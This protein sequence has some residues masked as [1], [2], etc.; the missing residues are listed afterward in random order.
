MSP[1][2]TAF[3]TAAMDDFAAD[4]GGWASE[5][6]AE[7]ADLSTALDAF[8]SSGSEF[9]PSVPAH[10]GRIES[11]GDRTAAL[12]DSVGALAA[13]A[14]EADRRGVADFARIAAR[15]SEGLPPASPSSMGWP[16]SVRAKLSA[17]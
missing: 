10:G 16:P 13:A 4:A 14:E 17:A 7:A 5:L 3:P 6:R 9:M 8:R 1:A 2:A 15:L 12:G 11:L